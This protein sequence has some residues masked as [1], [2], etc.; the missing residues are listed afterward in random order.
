MGGGG[1]ASKKLSKSSGGSGSSAMANGGTANEHEFESFVNGKWVTDYSK[2]AA[3]E[4]KKAAV[5]VDSSRYKKTHNDVVSFVKEQVGVDLNKYRSGDGS[6]PSHTTY[7][8]KSGPKVAFDLKGMSSSDRTKL[9]QLAQKPF[10]V[11]VEQGGAWIG[12][13]SRKKKKK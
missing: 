2:I 11:T 1:R 10:G 8:D 9:M 4:T 7:W 12:F 3:V 6:S 5:V 13:V